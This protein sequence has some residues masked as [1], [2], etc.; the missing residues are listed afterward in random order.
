MSNLERIGLTA[1]ARRAPFRRLVERAR[2]DVRAALEAYEAPFVACS[3][4]K[5]SAVL[6][7]LVHETDPSVPAR[8]LRWGESEMLHEYGEVMAAWHRRYPELVVHVLDLDRDSVDEAVPDRW[9]QL[10][11]LAP[12]D[13]YFSGLRAEESHARAITLSIHG[14]TYRTAAGITRICPLASWTTRDVAAYAV[15][16]DLPML[17]AYAAEGWDTRTTARVPREDHGIRSYAL[18]Q[19]KARNPEGFSRLCIK[20]PELAYHV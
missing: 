3:F 19:L 20:F 13:A 10:H 18:S 12:A 7:H 11:T 5:D 17:A 8:F 6:L 1:H 4:G 9:T 14:T 2:R 16:H 15:E